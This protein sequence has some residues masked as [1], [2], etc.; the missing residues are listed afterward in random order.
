MREFAKETR[1]FPRWRL[2]RK[3]QSGSGRW[4]RNRRRR[5]YVSGEAAFFSNALK[6]S[7]RRPFHLRCQS[8]WQKR[9]VC[10][11]TSFGLRHFCH[12]WER[13]SWRSNIQKYLRLPAI[14][15]FLDRETMKR[16]GFHVSPLLMT[17]VVQSFAG[18]F[19]F[20]KIYFAFLVNLRLASSQ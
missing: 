13:C 16:D 19:R 2:I 17:G 14:V 5:K 11:R 18:D 12:A 3:R 15:V 10:G 7:P 9:A 1:E 8:S 4:Q 6:E 20:Q